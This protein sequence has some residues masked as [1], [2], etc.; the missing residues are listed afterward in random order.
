[1]DPS[2]FQRVA[3]RVAEHADANLPDET[4][5]AHRPPGR[6]QRNGGGKG[7]SKRSRPA[8]DEDMDMPVR[9]I[10]HGPPV[11]CAVKVDATSRV[12]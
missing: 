4:V 1:M 11:A 8:V 5:N 6:K 2:H 10:W 7:K 12:E 3:A 9:M